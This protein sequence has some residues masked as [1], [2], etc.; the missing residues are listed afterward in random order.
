MNNNKKRSHRVINEDALN[1][2][3]VAW[4]TVFSRTVTRVGQAG[5][6]EGTSR[7]VH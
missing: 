1:S 6:Q 3:T 2:V 4:E 7:P 5:Y